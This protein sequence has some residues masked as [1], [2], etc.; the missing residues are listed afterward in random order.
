MLI[1]ERLGDGL[2]EGRAAHQAPEVDG[3]TTVRASADLVP[4][5]LVRATVVSSDG[6]DL[7]A[8]AAEQAMTPRARSLPPHTSQAHTVQAHTVPAHIVPAHTCPARTSRARASP[9]RSRRPARWRIAV[10]LPRVGF[11]ATRAV[12]G[13][14][15]ALRACPGTGR[16]GGPGPCGRP[17]PCS[18]GPAW[19]LRPSRTLWRTR[20]LLS[21]RAWST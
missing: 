7:V 14:S 19:T 10:D 18:P 21:R 9:R 4:G 11:T 17:G 12:W 8:T 13:G 16:C 3:T 1:E 6:V 2:F 5:Q 20:A 15:A